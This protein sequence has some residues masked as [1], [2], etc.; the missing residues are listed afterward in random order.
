MKPLEIIS[1]PRG[2]PINSGILSDLDD[3]INRFDIVFI[4]DAFRPSMEEKINRWGEDKNKLTF[5]YVRNERDAKMLVNLI[6]F[7][8]RPVPEATLEFTQDLKTSSYLLSI[9][10]QKPLDIWT[11]IFQQLQ[12]DGNGIIPLSKDFMKKDARDRR[13]S[14]P[15]QKETTD[16]TIGEEP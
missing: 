1:I 5:I 12:E 13:R 2:S 15:E 8:L 11:L 4:H 7:H 3:L 10:F 9:M 14:N 6:N 16:N